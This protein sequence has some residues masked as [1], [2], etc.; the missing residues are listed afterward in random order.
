M[1]HAS[2]IAAGLCLFGLLRAQH[3]A[4]LYQ[5]Y[6]SE[7]SMRIV[8]AEQPADDKL[9]IHVQYAKE[10]GQD[11]A[12]YQGYLIAYLDRNAAKVPAPAPADVLDPTAMVILH[13]QLMQRRE[14]KNS[15]GPQTYDL[16]FEISCAEL[17]Q[18]LVAHGK[19]GAADRDDRNG[20]FRY[21]DRIRFALFV[22]WLE[23]KKY[24]V[25]P[26]LPEDRHECNYLGSRALVFQELPTR[27]EFMVSHDERNRGNV[28]AKLRSGQAVA[29]EPAAK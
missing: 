18:K 26:G 17:V 4:P 12:A 21:R 19:F 14:Q 29:A 25:L 11:P 27:A 3:C 9:R 6:L 20:W 15:P 2:L 23:D 1:H 28:W 8:R 24:S 16:D 10:G 7:V 13:T 22:P 5:T